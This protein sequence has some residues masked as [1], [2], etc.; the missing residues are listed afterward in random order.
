VDLINLKKLFEQGK[1]D[2]V[3]ENVD[4]IDDPSPKIMILKGWTLLSKGEFDNALQIVDKFIDTSHDFRYDAIILKSRILYKKGFLDEALKLSLGIVDDLSNRSIDDQELNG[5]NLNNIGLIYQKKGELDTALEYHQTSLQIFEE[6]GNKQDIAKIFMNI[7][8]IYLRK[9]EFDTALEY[10]QKSLQI[11]EEIGNKQ[12]ISGS[13]NNI[14]II[15][16]SKGE[17]EAAL[18]YHQKSLQI[19]EEIGNKQDISGSFNNIGNIYQRKGELDTALEYYQKG[20][21]IIEEIG[22][23]QDISKAFNNIGNIYQK[24]GELDTALE[25]HQKSLHIREDIGN[26]QDIATTFNNIGHIYSSKGELDTALEYYQ[27]SLQIRKGIGNPLELSQSL[28]SIIDLMLTEDKKLAKQYLAQL[29]QSAKEN[30]NKVIS[31]RSR[32]AEALILK[33]S[34]RG[35]LIAKAQ[36]I[37]EIIIQEEI[38]NFAITR[39]AMLNLCEILLIEYKNFEEDE[40]LEEASDLLNQLYSKAQEQS[41]FSLSI[42]SLILK[43]RIKIIHGEFNQATKFLEQARLFAEER[44]ITGLIP[45]IEQEQKRMADNIDTWKEML[46]KTRSAGERM[47]QIQ[48]VEYLQEIK[49][50]HI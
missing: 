35:R 10:Y 16:L 43:A 21:Q 31:Q 37:L 45:K 14:G 6:S 24:K 28:F 5:H 44:G 13:L 38:V 32:L 9:G 33:S 49:N 17:L 41:S 22:N 42:E 2:E 1:F 47:E 8:N 20:L 4:R 34:N 12:D 27:K 29:Q 23:K 40:I 39:D 46:V 25:Y 26:N 30:D 7:G 50:I 18:E 36:D 3:I 19:R 15:Y 11:R 48:I